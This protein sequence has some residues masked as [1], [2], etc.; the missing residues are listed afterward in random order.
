MNE[1]TSPHNVEAEEAYLGACHLEPTMLEVYSVPDEAFYLQK[2]RWI[3]E[4]MRA[5]HANG[6]LD[7][8]SLVTELERHKRLEAVGG[9]A[10]LSQLINSCES[11]LYAERY[12]KMIVETWQKRQILD[13]VSE[14]A[15]QSYNGKT[16]DEIITFG[17]KSLTNLGQG[18][19]S[20]KTAEAG[21]VS[22][23]TK[24]QA[25]RLNP[26]SP[27]EVRGIS[28]GYLD[29][30]NATGGLFRGNVYYLYA[31]EHV[32]KTWTLINM[33]SKVC[34]TGRRALF[35]SLEMTADTDVERV[36]KTTLWDR[37]VLSRAGITLDEYRAGTLNDR[38]YDVLNA[39]SD[40]V[41]G[42]NLKIDDS[43]SSF[44]QISATIHRENR[45]QPLDVVAIDYLGL[46]TT[47]V[48]TATRN[49]QLGEITRALKLLA[50]AT[51]TVLLVPHQVSSKEL[52][53]RD[54]KRPT[55]ESG[56]ESGHIAQNADVVFYIYRD[57][58][59]HPATEMSRIIECK[60]LKDRVSGHTG[61]KWF[62]YWGRSCAFEPATVSTKADVFL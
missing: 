26:L 39:A 12:A 33:L 62:W 22:V 15:R 24:A 56:Y 17:S 5:T 52:L 61:R 21:A 31:A 46:I 13:V 42:W 28:T 30:N 54:D 48:K 6:G 9:V 35:F 7:F 10:Y 43:L 36:D 25:Y 59:Y 18:S 2:N 37:F 57:E 16:P 45:R 14:V 38:Q 50:N 29:M 53:R 34:A 49:E 60:L 32:G 55:I 58:I 47:T 3:H 4:A 40:E 51:D 8:L 41:A 20:L 1:K 27:G 44:D 19:T 23:L 11:Y